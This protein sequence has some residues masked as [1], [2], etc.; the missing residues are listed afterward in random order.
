LDALENFQTYFERIM[1]MNYVYLD[2]L[3]VDIGKEICPEV[4]L[5]SHQRARIDEEPQVYLHR[6]CCLKQHLQWM[7]DGRPPS[8]GQ[9]FYTQSMLRDACSLTS[10]YPKRSLLRKDGLVYSQYYNSVKE[11]TDA[12]KTRLFQND[13]LEEMALDPQIRQ[14]ACHAARMAGSRSV[15][16]IR[17][18]Y[19]ASKRRVNV[20]VAGALQKS[21]GIRE[22]HR[23]SWSL[24][25]ALQRRLRHEHLD[26]MDMTAPSCP[27]YVWP[28][29]TSVYLSYLWRNADKF[30]AGFEVVLAQCH[31]YFVTWEQT[32]IMAMF[33]R[34]LR[35]ALDGV[36]F[37]RES[38]LWWSRRE[39]NH[40][41]HPRTWYGLGFSNTLPRYGYCWLEPRVDWERMTFL[42]AVSDDVLFGNRILQ[43]QYLA[44]GGSVRDF[45][46]L[47]LQL[48]RALNWLQQYAGHDQIRSQLLTLVVHICLQQ[49]RIDVLTSV[50]QEIQDDQR[51]EAL[52]G[53]RPFSFEYFTDI[54]TDPVH[55]VS[56]NKT[57]FKAPTSL[58]RMLW[59]FDDGRTRHHWENK[60]YR[61]LYRRAC[62]VL[63]LHHGPDGLVKQ[64]RR[65][66][67]RDFFTYHWVLPYPCPEVFTQTTKQGA[68]MWYS[69]H[70]GLLQPSR[71]VPEGTP[72]WVWARKQWQINHPPA[73]PRCLKWSTAEWDRWILRHVPGVEDVDGE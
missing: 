27:E 1:D 3:Y 16:V 44:R 21:F 24:F 47:F 4:S 59:N 56:G 70:I 51:E 64:F 34:C 25:Q 14:G 30:A 52:Q 6:R 42:T 41:Q 73:L 66:L 71:N 18:A 60:P 55:L 28:L 69:V 9:R 12:A 63:N 37:P 10:L 13:G 40:P 33:L 43:R 22:E 29:Q 45:Q 50:Q 20:A 23:V 68:R 46:D 31:T 35:F 48:E 58:R 39:T 32:K 7:Y 57:E 49:F 17:N 72:G 53:Q 65:D 8:D 19:C 38:A 15:K 54:M 36:Q 61:K 11:V 26:D 67:Q 5:L 2:R 62:V